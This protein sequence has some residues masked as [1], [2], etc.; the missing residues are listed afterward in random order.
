MIFCPTSAVR[1][2]ERL[3]RRVRERSDQ[4]LGVTAGRGYLDRSV[5]AYSL[6]EKVG[7]ISGETAPEYFL[8]GR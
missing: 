7:V 5:R 4:A 6:P 3:A 8:L 2:P 1:C